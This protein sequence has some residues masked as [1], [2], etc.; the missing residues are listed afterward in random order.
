M[1]VS[2]TTSINELKKKGRFGCKCNFYQNLFQILEYQAVISQI[3]GTLITL[4]LEKTFAGKNKA[5]LR[6]R[7]KT[8]LLTL[9]ELERTLVG[10]VSVV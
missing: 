6:N 2:L 7:W 3:F 9:F 5:C 1:L 10:R 8:K 4:K